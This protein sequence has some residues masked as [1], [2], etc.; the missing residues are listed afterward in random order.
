MST[1]SNI[2]QFTN[3]KRFHN[4]NVQ[5]SLAL[6]VIAKCPVG[7]R[8]INYASGSNHIESYAATLSYININIHKAYSGLN[9]TTQT[10][11]T[12][13]IQN[14]IFVIERAILNVKNILALSALYLAKIALEPFYV[15]FS[16]YY[17]AKK[18]CKAYLIKNAIHDKLFIQ[19][20]CYDNF[21]INFLWNNGNFGKGILSRSAPTWLNRFEDFTQKNENSVSVEQFTLD[22][23]SK[24]KGEKSH[25]INLFGSINAETSSS[26]EPLQL[27]PC[28]TLYLSTAV[29]CLTI[30][31]K[32]NNEFSLEAVWKLLFQTESNSILWSNKLLVEY[33]VYHFY[34]SRGWIV[35]NGLKFSVDFVLYKSGPQSSHS[36]YSVKII[37]V[38][39]GEIKSDSDNLYKS[40]DQDIRILMSQSRICSQVKKRLF[41]CYVE[42]PD[43]QIPVQIPIYD[44]SIY[45][46]TEISVTRFNPETNR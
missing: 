46:I 17:T 18:N 43:L 20:W 8:F 37:P 32:F 27:T 1:K 44:L 19:V 13:F 38:T 21:S 9:Q 2:K 39:S 23:R 35:K 26:M 14:G 24:K 30:L 6:P 42:I 34:K 5:E 11:N 33:A 15:F 12:S 36:E 25:N 45:K 10:N 7:I 3:E 29:G 31:D 40:Y 28:E 16:K 22:R 41:L 4:K